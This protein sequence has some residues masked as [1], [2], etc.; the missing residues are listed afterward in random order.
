MAPQG[1]TVCELAHRIPGR[2]RDLRGRMMLE[3]VCES[4]GVDEV[5]CPA[6]DGTGW[7]S[8]AFLSPCPVCC[9][10]REVPDGLADWFRAQRAAVRSAPLRPDPADLRLDRRPCRPG[11]EVRTRPPAS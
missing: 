5:T 7:L 6:C 11:H 8:R 1:A 3:G 2:L 9:G 10:F 4:L